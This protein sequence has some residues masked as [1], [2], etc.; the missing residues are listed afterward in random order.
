MSQGF[1]GYRRKVPRRSIHTHSKRKILHG[2][3]PLFTH[4]SEN[5][6]DARKLASGKQLGQVPQSVRLDARRA[7]TPSPTAVYQTTRRGLAAKALRPLDPWNLFLA[8]QPPA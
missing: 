5:K 8:V 3:I 6:R 2:E 1:R 4:A 7:L